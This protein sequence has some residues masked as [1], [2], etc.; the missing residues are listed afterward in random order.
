VRGIYGRSLTAQVAARFGRAF[1]IFLQ[2]RKSNPLVVVGKDTRPSGKELKTAVLSGLGAIPCKVADLRVVPSPTVQV[3]MDHLGADGGLIITASHNPPEWNGFK[4][5]IGPHHIVLDREQTEEL[6]RLERQLE[7]APFE[8]FPQPE[9]FDARAEALQCHMQRVLA[10]VDVDVIGARRFR[11]CLDA[12]AGAGAEPGA[13]LLERL[14]C[15]VTTLE[16]Q[17]ESEPTPAHLAGLCQA[18]KEHGCD[19]GMAQDMDA[20]RVALV[21]EKGEAIGEDYTFALAVRHLLAKWRG[22]RR[23]VVFKSTA[24]SRMVDDI[25]AQAGAEIVEKPVGEVNLSKAAIAAVAEGRNA[26]AGEGTGGVIHP[27]VCFGR[28]SLV[29]AALVLEHLAQS[30]MPLSAAAAQL[31]TYHI[32]KEAIEGVDADAVPGLLAAVKRNYAGRDISEADGVKIRLA[33]RSWILV[34]PSNTEPLVRLVIEAPAR[35]R[36]EELMLELRRV[37]AEALGS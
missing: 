4:F 1:A 29:G 34:R 35:Q 30:G 20:D 8:A 13:T 18:V 36:A 2:H 19:L 9:S 7:A 21:S 11:V 24:T 12:G 10:Q 15:D 5:L 14:G 17:R 37:S 23:P 28:D 3:M 16:V 27:G 6:F 22:D 31:P 33:D 26:V 32:L 25:V